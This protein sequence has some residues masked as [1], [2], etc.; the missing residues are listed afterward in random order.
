[1]TCKTTDQLRHE[2]THTTDIGD[3]LTTNRQNLLT[4]DLSE[5]LSL[6][7]SAKKLHK[8][9]V[10]R[11]SLLDR[12]YLYQI[13]AGKRFPSRSKLIAIAFGLHLSLEETQKLLKI[14]E[15]RELYV[16][17]ERD[18]VIFYALQRGLDIF[19]TNELL[20]ERG[21]KLLGTSKK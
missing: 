9:D 4:Q 3:F 19:D 11:D 8:A 12:V 15:N 14:S 1:M 18:A 13:F 21:L 6:L 7:L 2:I 16:R 10:V 5:H 20:Y 17:D